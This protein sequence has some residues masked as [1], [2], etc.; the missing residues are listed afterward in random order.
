MIHNTIWSIKTEII[1]LPIDDM[2]QLFGIYIIQYTFFAPSVAAS[3]LISDAVDNCQIW[4]FLFLQH[5]NTPYWIF[6]ISISQV[7]D[8]GAVIIIIGYYCCRIQF[9]FSREPLSRAESFVVYIEHSQNTQRSNTSP[10]KR[11]SA[12]DD[13]S[14]Q[15]SLQGRVSLRR[16][17]V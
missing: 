16:S 13:S 3:N 14:R 1:L 11:Q 17:T 15:R 8:C 12:P 6:V 4:S 5:A 7:S 10:L 2:G 9:F